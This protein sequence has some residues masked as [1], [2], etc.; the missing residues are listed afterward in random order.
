MNERLS[1]LQW[2]I[3]HANVELAA[4]LPQDP[5]QLISHFRKQ[6]SPQRSRLLVELR[7]LR[8]RGLA[9]FS[10]AELMFFTRRGLEQATDERLAGYKAN[11]FPPNSSVV[12]ICCG[13]GGDLISLAGRGPTVGVD[14]DALILAYAAANLRVHDVEAQLNCQTASNCNVSRV[15]AWHLDPDRRSA[16]QKRSAPEY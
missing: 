9:K 8:T 1:E 5:L 10:R 13:V 11:R 7:E 4:E 12:D 2:L 3:E 6:H 14:K 16:D 15:S